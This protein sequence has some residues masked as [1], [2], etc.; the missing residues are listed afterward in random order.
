MNGVNMIPG[1]R[2]NRRTS[3]I[4]MKVFGYKKVTQK[5]NIIN[6]ITTATLI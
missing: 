1:R 3:L 4:S 2:R 5:I 6:P